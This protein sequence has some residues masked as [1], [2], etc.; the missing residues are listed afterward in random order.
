MNLSA[1][2]RVP[3]GDES[4][5]LFDAIPPSIVD[6]EKGGTL[7]ERF[8]RFHRANPHVYRE[9]LRLSRMMLARG[10]KV[11]IATLYEVLRWNY[12]LHT[13]DESGFKLNQDYRSMYARLIMESDPEL[14]DF[15]EIRKLRARG[16]TEAHVAALAPKDAT[17]AG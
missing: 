6:D 9:L 7:V 5:S 4:P 8:A 15:F 3:P 14:K 11:G 16:T 2:L 12:V 1:R 10:R 13:D 17:G